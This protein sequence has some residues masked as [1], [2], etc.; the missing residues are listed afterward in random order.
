[1]IISSGFI[2]HGRRQAIEALL[3]AG[4]RPRNCEEAH[5]DHRQPGAHSAVLSND[6]V[7]VNWR[8]DICFLYASVQS[9]NLMV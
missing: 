6:G 2:D 8:P 9:G 7:E 1:M 5:I 4:R 3:S